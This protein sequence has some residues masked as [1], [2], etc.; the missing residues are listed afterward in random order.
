MPVTV[1]MCFK[2]ITPIYMYMFLH[3]M[4]CQVNEFTRRNLDKLFPSVKKPTPSF[5]SPLDTS[6]PSGGSDGRGGKGDK[7]KLSDSDSNWVAARCL[8]S[9]MQS[10]IKSMDIRYV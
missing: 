2:R 3:R 9:L 1:C 8:L 5:F 10:M 4:F 7:E 6:V